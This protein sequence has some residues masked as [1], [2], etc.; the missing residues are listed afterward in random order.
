MGEVVLYGLRAKKSSG[1]ERDA[2][3][4]QNTSS[5]CLP[6]FLLCLVLLK[7]FS[8]PRYICNVLDV[9]GPASN[10]RRG[11]WIPPLNQT[12]REGEVTSLCRLD[13]AVVASGSSR[14]PTRVTKH[15]S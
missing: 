11:S 14:V 1:Q 2:T 10:L 15:R 13:H 4:E 5:A 3:R 7:L 8:C 12:V 9:L 6:L